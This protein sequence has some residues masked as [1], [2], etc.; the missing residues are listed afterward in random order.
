MALSKV[1]HVRGMSCNHCVMAVKKAL[2]SIDGVNSVDVELATGQVTVNFTDAV[3]DA[4][5]AEAIQD[6]GYQLA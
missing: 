5:V 3:D 4:V 6:A 1:Y 2:T